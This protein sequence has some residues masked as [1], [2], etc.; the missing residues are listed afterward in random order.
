[1]R[2]TTLKTLPVLLALMFCFSAKSRAQFDGEGSAPVKVTITRYKDKSYTATKTDPD[3]HT[4][5]T[6]KY[7]AA[8]K[9]MQTTVFTLDD[10]GRAIAGFVYA[11][12]GT[13]PKGMLRYKCRYVYDTANRV[14]EVD[15]YSVSDQL[16]SKQVYHYKA[17][18]TADRV[19]NYDPSGKLTSTTV[20]DQQ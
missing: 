7:D 8:G 5:E 16:I 4:A 1:M 18:G 19:D 11:P 12:Q 15:N 6:S 17:D 3:S 13:N 20:L 2:S 9:L 14:S 10:V